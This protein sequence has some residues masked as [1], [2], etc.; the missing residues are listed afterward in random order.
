MRVIHTVSEHTMVEDESWL[1][2][3]VSWWHNVLTLCKWM[4]VPSSG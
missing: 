1:L 4:I 3:S 2:R